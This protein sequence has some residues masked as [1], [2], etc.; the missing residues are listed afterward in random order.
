MIPPEIKK[1]L[2]IEWQLFIETVEWVGFGDL[3]KVVIQNGKPIHAKKVVD[4]IKFTN[5]DDFKDKLR[6]KPSF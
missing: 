2:L 1:T 6:T 3:E 4:D 5:R